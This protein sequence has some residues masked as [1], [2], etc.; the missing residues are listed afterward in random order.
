MSVKTI[1]FGLLRASHP[2]P[3]VAIS[4]MAVA[5]AVAFGH[6]L[7]GIIALTVAV[8]VGQLSVGWHNDWLDS[9]Q[10]HDVGRLDKPVSF[11]YSRYDHVDDCS[12]IAYDI[13]KL[14][15]NVAKRPFEER[16][17]AVFEIA[18]SV[19]TQVLPLLEKGCDDHDGSL[20][21]LMDTAYIRI[22]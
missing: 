10:D 2:E 17:P 4:L 14:Y 7:V 3:T 8:L 1:T 9:V 22:K 20:Y 16:S 13:E 18:R 19:I 11:D 6:N 5:L 21:S 15:V 12:D